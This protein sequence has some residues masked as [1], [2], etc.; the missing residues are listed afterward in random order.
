VEAPE[1]SQEE[2]LDTFVVAN[3]GRPVSLEAEYA[4]D[5]STDLSVL[6]DHLGR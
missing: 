4:K 3:L 5:G 2:V 6:L 1:L